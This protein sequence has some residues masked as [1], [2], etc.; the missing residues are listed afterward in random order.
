MPNGWGD[1]FAEYSGLLTSGTLDTLAMLFVSTGIAYVFGIVLGVVL[2]LTSPIGLK[3]HRIFNAVLGWIVNM[4]RSIPFIILLVALMPATRALVH[5]TTGVVGV[6]PPLVASATPFVARM[7]EQSLAEV[8]RDTLESVVSFGASMPRI[9][10]GALLPEALPSIVR[11][12]S[13]TL[14]SV[15][16]YTAIAGAVGAGGLGD[17]AIRYG[18]YRYEDEVMIVT[19]VLLVVLVQVI[20]RVCDL[21]A[22]HI[23]HR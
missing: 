20:Q 14:I 7:I 21:I 4:A 11:G 3:P 10:L 2:Y 9:V 16:G 22:N 17:I 19:V 18:Y 8:P 23:D 15:L 6:T 13:I 1:F 5:T 12:V